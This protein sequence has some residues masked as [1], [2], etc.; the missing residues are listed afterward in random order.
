MSCRMFHSYTAPYRSTQLQT[1][2]RHAFNPLVDWNVIGVLEERT[3]EGSWSTMCCQPI[4]PQT[5]RRTT[6]REQL[7]KREGNSNAGRRHVPSSFLTEKEKDTK[8]IK[9]PRAQ[10]ERERE[11]DKVPD[12]PSYTLS[13]AVRVIRLHTLSLLPSQTERQP[14]P[15]KRSICTSHRNSRNFI[16]ILYDYP[17]VLQRVG[18]IFLLYFQ[19][20]VF[21]LRPSEPQVD[22]TDRRALLTIIRS[23]LFMIQTTTEKHS[24]LPL[25]NNIPTIYVIK[26]VNS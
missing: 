26:L 13:D 4:A 7:S 24:R 23:L 5:H 1:S 22:Q 12:A 10:R 3:T 6:K 18:F 21:L 16:C 2:S 20:F 9:K 15:N 8:N 25:S 11:R 19:C 14:F 17:F